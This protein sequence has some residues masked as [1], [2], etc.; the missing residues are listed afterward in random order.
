MR[1]G[2]IGGSLRQPRGGPAAA[3]AWSGQRSMLAAVG[4]ATRPGAWARPRVQPD[5][6]RLAPCAPARGVRRP[7]AGRPGSGGSLSPLGQRR[8]ADSEGSEAPTAAAR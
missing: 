1:A 4:P 7:R 3:A 6:L 5:P 2:T 8:G